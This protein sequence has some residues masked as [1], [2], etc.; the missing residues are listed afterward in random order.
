[1]DAP[2]DAPPRSD[3]KQ[4]DRAAPSD[5]R[6]AEASTEAGD[7]DVPADEGETALPEQLLALIGWPPSANPTPTTGTAPA[8]TGTIRSATTADPTATV[9][10]ALTA[11]AL[12]GAA[13]NATATPAPQPATAGFPGTATPTAGDPTLPG[14][15]PTAAAAMP[16][17]ADV[18]PADFARMFALAADADPATTGET[19][20]RGE[21]GDGGLLL[22]ATPAP[23]TS[24]RNPATAITATP[25][26]MPAD[27]D[28]GF[29][30]AFGAR[31]SWMAEQGIGRAELRLNPEHLGVI[32]IRLQIDGNRISAE[33]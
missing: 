20:G 1:M 15:D 11:I 28:A 26:T 6:V 25:L 23:A 4:A 27:P 9:P 2:A 5:Q 30:D 13:A 21:T 3:K 31:I 18:P 24:A 17:D 10:Q 14:L 32:D 7:D 29:D 16:V 19:A 33:F 8:V 22:S 12:D